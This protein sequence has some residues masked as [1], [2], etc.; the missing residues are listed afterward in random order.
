MAAR[1]ATMAATAAIVPGCES[2]AACT[3]PSKL[4]LLDCAFSSFA[5]VVADADGAWFFGA[6]AGAASAG[7]LSC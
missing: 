5:E 3:F 7:A 6:G 1:V 4:G 2:S